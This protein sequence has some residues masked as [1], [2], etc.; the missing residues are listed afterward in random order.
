M[1]ISDILDKVVIQGRYEVKDNSVTFDWS[2]SE[3]E[4]TADCVGKV[5]V[6][7]TSE[8]NAYGETDN[9]VQGLT[10]FAA[11]VDGERVKDDIE[12]DNTT[13]DIVLAEN[14]EKGVHTF[15]LA[16]QTNVYESQAQ[17]NSV[18][19]TGE[20]K[21]Q[22]KNKYY[23]EFL[24]DSYTSGYGIRGTRSET[25]R[26]MLDDATQAYAYLTAKQLGADYQLSAFSGA[27]FA[28][29]YTKFTIPEV[30]GYQNWFRDTEKE[31][32]FDRVPDLLVMNLGTNDVAMVGTGER[33]TVI[34]G[35]RDLMNE[36]YDGYSKKIPIVIC[37]DI[38]HENNDSAITEAFDTY[39][40]DV[41]YTLA[42]LTKDSNGCNYHPNAAGAAKQA[43]ELVDAIRIFKPDLFPEDKE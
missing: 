26:P 13:S 2:G 17:I 10:C 39:F 18:T 8:A 7:V 41:E 14:I 32:G 16:R 11:F 6:N 28:F 30:Y 43:L 21:E 40:P 25:Y 15:R 34:E 23:I 9:G 37:T 27:G 5:S 12:V 42:C 4:F 19:L 22:E 36:V 1:N 33:E 35:I 38:S 20:L 24:G 31:Y 3:I 29:G